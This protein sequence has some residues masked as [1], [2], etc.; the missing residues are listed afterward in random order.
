MTLADSTR[1]PTKSATAKPYKDFPLFRHRNGQ[2]A[3]KV[4]GK[5]HYFGVDHNEALDLWLK[6]KDDLL[7]GRTPREGKD[8][9]LTVKRLCDLF[10]EHVDARVETGERTKRLFDD[11]QAQCIDLADRLGRNTPVEALHPTDFKRLRSEL[12]KGVSLKTL[13][14]RIVRVRAVFNYAV[15]NNLIGVNLARLWGVE[16][17]KP[18]RTAIQKQSDT[19]EKLFTA[20]QIKAILDVCESPQMRAMILLGINSGIGNTDAAGIEFDDIDG[21]WL[22]RRRQ[23]TGK[24][25]RIPLWKETREAIEAAIAKRPNHKDEA[26]SVRIFITKYGSS[27]IP[28]RGD[29]PITKEFAKLRKEAKLKH[30]TFY[31]L[32]HTFQTIAD[33]T[34]DFVA[35]STL[36]GHVDHSISGVYRERISDERLKAVTNHVHTWLFGKAVTK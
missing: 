18:E 12:A 27:W 15:K 34:K 3:K 13:E 33:E 24:R 26:D 17:E 14:G 8:D 30:G 1:K 25:R 16:F 11:Y 4:R 10:C 22:T 20:K 5:L 29:D 28:T 35:V 2:W 23:K 6:Q 21:E 19:R 36:M 9:E 31:W 32:R 7:A